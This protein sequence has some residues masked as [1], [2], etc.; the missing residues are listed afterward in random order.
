M[1]ERTERSHLSRKLREQ[2]LVQDFHEGVSVRAEGRNAHD[3]TP[4]MLRLDEC[5]IS[6]SILISHARSSWAEMGIVY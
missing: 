5:G 1:S 6:P 2:R 3:I 4:G